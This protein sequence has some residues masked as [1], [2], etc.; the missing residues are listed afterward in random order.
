MTILYSTCFGEGI[1]LILGENLEGAGVYTGEVIH[2]YLCPT[3]CVWIVPGT[4]EPNDLV[5]V[6]A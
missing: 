6:Q 2:K 3:D 5:H 1:V 4:E